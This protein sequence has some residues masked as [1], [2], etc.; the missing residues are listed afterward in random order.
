MN[1]V[2]WLAQDGALIQLR[3]RGRKSRPIKDYYQE[4]MAALGGPAG[5]AV[6]NRKLDRQA[7]AQRRQAHRQIAWNN[8]LLPPFA[9]L[10]AALGHFGYRRRR[11]RQP[12]QSGENV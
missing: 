5:T 6:E 9:M 7:K 12:Y 10:F 8:V 2:D 3:S 1:L 11:A 4:T